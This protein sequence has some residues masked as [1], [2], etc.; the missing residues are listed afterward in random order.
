MCFG[1]LVKMRKSVCFPFSA[2]L[3]LL[4]YLLLSLL[5]SCFVMIH[6]VWVAYNWT[7]KFWTRKLQCDLLGLPN[8][9]RINPERQHLHQNWRLPTMTIS[10]VTRIKVG[11]RTRISLWRSAL[12]VIKKHTFLQS[13]L[14]VFNRFRA[15]THFS[16]L[17]NL[18]TSFREVP[19]RHM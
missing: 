13:S 10:V 8:P 16:T 19:V 1:L 14:A 15:A 2:L 9:I 3:F 12:K 18:T 11:S 6:S 5:P 17:F 7:Y 4:L